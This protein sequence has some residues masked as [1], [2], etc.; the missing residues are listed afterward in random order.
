MSEPLQ[1]DVP[2]FQVSSK[3]LLGLKVILLMAAILF[4]TGLFL[5]MMT[6][7]TLVFFDHSFSIASGVYELLLNQKYAL[8][9]LIAGFSIALPSLKIMLLFRVLLALQSVNDKL[10]R[11]LYL[12]H[13]YGRWS[14]LDVMV[15][16]VLIV[17]V[18]LGAIATIETH[19]G[20]YIF[21]VAVLLIM[22]VTNRVV[23]LADQVAGG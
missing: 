7:T 12:M 3:Q 18:K 1:A 6:L 11:Y 10:R 21:A 15:V 19:F 23:R 8:F 14:M 4:V 22:L 16:A 17:T 5:P 13:E 9:I 20:L 2:Q